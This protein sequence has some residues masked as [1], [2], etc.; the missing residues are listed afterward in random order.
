[1]PQI[2]ING[3]NDLVSGSHMV[4]RYQEL[5]ENARVVSLGEGVGHYPQVEATEKV[6]K[7]YLSFLYSL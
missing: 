2:L 5:V 1:M 7:E 3:P 6:A 4:R